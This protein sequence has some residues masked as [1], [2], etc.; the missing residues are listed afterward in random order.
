MSFK[1]GQSLM[2]SVKELEQNKGA[3]T[4]GVLKDF[5]TDWLKE[6]NKLAPRKSG[7]YAAS[8]KAGAVTSTKATVE[9]PQGELYKILEFTGR[10]A[11]RIDAPAGGVLAFK[12]KGIDVFFKFVNHPGFHKMPHVKP[13]MRR[14]MGRSD[15]IF[16]RNLKK[17]FKLFK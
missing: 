17:H 13:A 4:K 12:W 9:T 11:G 8:W 6:I 5:Q 7:D 3:F 15:Q 10:T 16:R 1:I 2:N 14:V